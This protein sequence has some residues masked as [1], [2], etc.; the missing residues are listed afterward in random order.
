MFQCS[1]IPKLLISPSVAQTSSNNWLGV[2]REDQGVTPE[3]SHEWRAAG[4][5]R[6]HSASGHVCQVLALPHLLQGINPVAANHVT[7][8]VSV[9]DLHIQRTPWRWDDLPGRQWW[10]PGSQWG[11]EQMDTGWGYELRRVHLWRSLPLHVRQVC[12]PSLVHHYTSFLFRVTE[13]LDFI[14]ASMVTNPFEDFTPSYNWILMRV[15][16]LWSRFV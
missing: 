16:L 14:Y 8:L 12:R 10:S 4:G 3:A 5:Q 1:I 11:F 13:F 7:E 15:V 9:D 2:H 6:V